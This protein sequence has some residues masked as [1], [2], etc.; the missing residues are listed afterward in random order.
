MARHSGP[1]IDAALDT[2]TRKEII[3][4]GRWK[5]DRSVLRY[6]QRARLHKSFHRLPAAFQAY[7]LRCENVFAQSDLQLRSNCEPP[8]ASRSVTLFLPRRPRGAYF[9]VL[10]SAACRV[11]RRI[12]QRGLRVGWYNLTLM[13][14]DLRRLRSD[15]RSGRMLGAVLCPSCARMLCLTNE[16][17]VV[18][19]SETKKSCSPHIRTG[20][21][22]FKR[23]ITFIRD[24]QTL[25]IPWIFSRLMSGAQHRFV[26][27]NNIIEITASFLTSGAFG[28][29]WKIRTYQDILSLAEYS[30]GEH[31]V[32][33]F[34]RRPHILL[35]GSDLSGQQFTARCK[36]LPPRLCSKLCNELRFLFVQVN[37]D[38]FGSLGWLGTW[39]PHF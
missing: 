31:H 23:V 20:N 24:L 33:A 19:C 30:C 26:C 10:S 37:T 8:V 28:T 16:S 36:V 3:D 9:V 7:A 6:E 29:P 12:R 21:Q 14:A 22:Q 34:S 2:R 17:K 35:H 25:A 39:W 5:S 13:S 32:C 4:R 11:G 1:S 38:F 27:S 15:A 18:K